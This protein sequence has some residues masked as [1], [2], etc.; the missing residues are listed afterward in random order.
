MHHPVI[1]VTLRWYFTAS[2]AC[3][4]KDGLCLANPQRRWQSPRGS[5]SAVVLPLLVNRLWAGGK[6]GPLF[7]V[8]AA[9]IWSAL[10]DHD[11]HQRSAVTDYTAFALFRSAV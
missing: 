1:T 10:A 9:I 5:V 6:S 11:A 3:V 4:A 8:P 2:S 7:V